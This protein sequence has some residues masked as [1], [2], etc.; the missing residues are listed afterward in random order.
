MR[1]ASV[2]VCTLDGERLIV[3]TLRMLAS[4]VAVSAI[5]LSDIDTQWFPLLMSM[6]M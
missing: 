1:A 4:R 2:N 5:I 6:C 3:I